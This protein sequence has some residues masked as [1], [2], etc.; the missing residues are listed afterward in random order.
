MLRTA[1]IVLGLALSASAGAEGFSYT[2][3]S[4]GYG[5]TDFDEVDADGNGFLANGSIAFNENFHGFANLAL[6]ELD[7]DIVTPLGV[8]P[9]EVDATRWSAGFGYNRG[10]SEKVDLVTRLS[11]ESID[12]DVPGGDD[13]GYG[14][15]VG[16]RYAA[17][18]QFEVNAGIKRVDYS[19]F[20]DDTAFELGGLYSF[21][22]SW[23]MN[24]TGEFSDDV[25][26]LSLSARFYF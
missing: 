19:D 5:N 16:V 10:L 22:D 13:S 15:G 25:T 7:A 12:F 6:A 23:S 24:L 11:Y 4:L 9:V 8:I 21:N 17:A 14:L 26:I 18:D 1:M 3:A 2:Y 20:G